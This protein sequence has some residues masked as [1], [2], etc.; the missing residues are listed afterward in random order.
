MRIDDW[1]LHQI[2]SDLGI[3]FRFSKGQADIPV[4]NCWHF[5]TDGNAVDS[6]F[7]DESDFKDGMNR[8]ALVS[9]LFKVIIL[10][11][12]MMD[13]H[14]HFVLYGEEHECTRFVHEYL[15]R[16][17]Q[18]ISI[19]HGKRN[20]LT[21]LPVSCQAIDT[22][23]YLKTAVCYVLRNPTMAGIPVSPLDYQWSSG[24][25]M[26][27]KRNGWTSPSWCHE[28]M[29]TIGDMSHSDKRNFLKTRGSWDC[30][31]RIIDGIVFPGE[32]VAYEIVEQLFRTHKAFLFFLGMNK[33]NEI[34]TLQG[35]ISSLSIPDSEMRQH[36]KDICNELFGEGSIRNLDTEKRIVLARTMKKR[37]Q[38]SVKQIARLCG[39]AYDEVKDLI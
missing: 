3:N 29:E 12:A 15:R 8:I 22:Q 6:L 4:K 31:W 9:K 38:S 27:R 30:E 36:K 2:E 16:T 37:Y 26:F 19:R 35:R 10:A 28:T 13:N 7:E 11:F 33:E 24:P 25:L 17:S 32:Y 14:I 18:H 23:T 20:K 1:L 34:E 39:L 21:D 5:S